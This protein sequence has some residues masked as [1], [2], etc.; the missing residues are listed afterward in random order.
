MYVAELTCDPG[1]IERARADEFLAE[2]WVEEEAER[3]TGRARSATKRKR[4]TK[5]VARAAGE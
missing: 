1:H 5:G 4:E 3:V 2:R